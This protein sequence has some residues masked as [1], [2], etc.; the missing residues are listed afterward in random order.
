MQRARHLLDLPRAFRDARLMAANADT[1]HDKAADVCP[2]GSLGYEV[3]D[4]LLLNH[5]KLG[6]HD[7]ISNRLEV[8]GDGASDGDFARIKAKDVGDDEWALV[9]SD[10]AH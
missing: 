5:V 9:R 2:R 4:C 3:K 1:R 6:E 10:Q 8:H 7:L